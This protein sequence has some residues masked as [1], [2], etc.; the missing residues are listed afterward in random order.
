MS[1]STKPPMSR[2]SFIR[3]SA[4][5]ITVTAVGAELLSVEAALEGRVAREVNGS[6]VAIGRL[7]DL[8]EFAVGAVGRHE[9]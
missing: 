1:D 3:Q 6:Q 7:G 4:E 5:A 2:R 8:G 9:D